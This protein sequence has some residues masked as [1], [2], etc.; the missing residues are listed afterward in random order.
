MRADQANRWQEGPTEV[1]M[2]RG[3][4][5]V[6]QDT[7][8]A[9]AATPC[10]GS[11]AG[12]RSAAKDSKIIAYLEGDVVGGLLPAERPARRRPAC[13]VSA[14]RPALAGPVHDLDRDRDPGPGDRLRTASPAGDCATRPGGPRGGSRRPVQ[15]AQFS[16][17]AARLLPARPNLPPSSRTPAPARRPVAAPAWP[18]PP[19]TVPPGTAGPRRNS[20]R[21]RRRRRV[22]PTRPAAR[23]IVIRSRSNVRMEGKVF[24]SP[25]G[26]E[27]IAVITSGRERRRRRHPEPAR[28]GQ[29]QDRHRDRPDR[30]L[31]RALDA[32]RPDR[33][34][35]RAR[36]CSPR[37]R[38]WSSTW[39]ATSSSAK[40]IG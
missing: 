33:R 37:T 19:R 1:W 26:Q 34:S 7:V 6:A 3:N 28:L 38:R 20:C 39:K 9:Q 17:H 29:R 31:D 11:P 16:T 18:A 30:D 27:T 15:P 36:S 2:L 35:R 10:C 13:A 8:T 12:I 5:A 32:A 23:R 40:A 14:P 24:P 21:R 25:D 4:C 22:P